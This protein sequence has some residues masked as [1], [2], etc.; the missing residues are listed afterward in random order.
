MSLFYGQPKNNIKLTN[1]YCYQIFFFFKFNCP[2]YYP[3]KKKKSKCLVAFLRN[4]RN[5]E[6][7]RFKGKKKR[8]EEAE[9]DVEGL[10]LSAVVL[11]LCFNSF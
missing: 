9:I 4:L 10:R 1:N 6:R 3:K 11:C 7:R 2:K 8:E 5:G